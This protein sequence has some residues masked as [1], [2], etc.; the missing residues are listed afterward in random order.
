MKKLL[1]AL[2][3][4][5]F[6]SGLFAQDCA[7]FE[8]F[9]DFYTTRSSFGMV[10]GNFDPANV[11]TNPPVT[12]AAT[13][14]RPG[15][16]TLICPGNIVELYAGFDWIPTA[17]ITVPDAGID[18]FMMGLKTDSFGSGGAYGGLSGSASG[19]IPI[20]IFL[21]DIEGCIV[22]E[23]VPYPDMYFLGSVAL[24]MRNTCT[25][26]DKT[27]RAE[28]ADAEGII[29]FNRESEGPFATINMIGDADT[30]NIPAWITTWTQGSSIIN[31]IDLEERDVFVNFCDRK[32]TETNWTKDGVPY[33]T[34]TLSNGGTC[35]D[36]PVGQ[37]R[38]SDFTL[39]IG[40][41]PIPYF[42]DTAN[43]L[44]SPPPCGGQSPP[45]VVGIEDDI[46]SEKVS[47]YPNPTSGLV[48]LSMGDAA[49]TEV[50]VFAVD[51][52]QVISERIYD[53]IS[54]DLDL[55]HLDN[56]IYLIRIKQGNSVA[57]K[58]VNV[59]K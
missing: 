20:K 7:S 59:L 55:S 24:V 50:S 46:L 48:T 49:E 4:L 43:L 18:S 3:L 40:C 25:F 9:Y 27:A 57:M 51:G 44:I 41:G 10:E 16:D 36:G 19:P 38:I 56:G 58:R 30:L 26:D 12:R 28:S 15:G 17:Q 2:T 37:F 33:E 6:C 29:I 32:L 13:A 21:D 42:T 23:V 11:F 39:D 8:R 5:P 53:D 45:C 52:S 34:S 22:E 1:L 31:E 54:F 35:S 47:I 14:V